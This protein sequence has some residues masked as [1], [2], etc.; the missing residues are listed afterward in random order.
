MC[1][2][3]LITDKNGVHMER[4]GSLDLLTTEQVCQE[5]HV[6]RSTLNVYRRK[7]SFPEPLRIPPGA[8]RPRL[9][10]TRTAITEWLVRGQR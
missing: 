9:R 7:R 5:L 10:W 4:S 8:E 6:S 3:L 2:R 1:V